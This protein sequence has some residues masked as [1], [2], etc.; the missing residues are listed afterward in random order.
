MDQNAQKSQQAVYSLIKRAFWV[1]LKASKEGF[2]THDFCLECG[3][4]KAVLFI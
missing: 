1:Y 4:R 3:Q 2:L